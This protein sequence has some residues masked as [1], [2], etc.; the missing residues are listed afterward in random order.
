ML[1]RAF[2]VAALAI[3]L[4]VPARAGEKLGIVLMHGKDG[5]PDRGIA[6]LAAAL[7]RAGYLVDRPEMCWSR[8][9]I[10]DKSY[11]DCLAEID[12]A[13]ARLRA[14]GA[15][16]IVV[17][18]QSIGGAAAIAYGAR[19]AG[20]KGVIGIA[21][22]HF[23]E[24]VVRRSDIAASLA[25]A[26]AMIAA[27]RGDERAT[28]VDVNV[29][30]PFSVETTARIYASFFG[31]DSPGVLP[32]NAARLSAPLLYIAGS[33]DPTQPGPDYAFAKAPPNPLD[34]YVTVSSGHFNTPD[35]A[36]GAVLAWLEE[37]AR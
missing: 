35:A 13:V 3:A 34:R 23:P 30:A 37:L 2:L 27:G 5:S 19:H 12:L 21:P 16:A 17:A 36:T 6:G 14:R 15:T 29:G 4:A 25:K 8:H 32:A 10:Y 22:A 7:E 11:L 31:P 1:R 28:F 18:G 24:R 9:R 20:L 33:N 26:Q